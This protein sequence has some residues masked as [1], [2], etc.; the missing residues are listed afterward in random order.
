[1]P[2]SAREPKACRSCH[3]CT[4]PTT[5]CTSPSRLT[6]QRFLFGRASL[7]SHIHQGLCDS[8]TSDH[9]SL[10][11]LSFRPLYMDLHFRLRSSL[12]KR[13]P[14]PPRNI[15][16]EER[17]FVEPQR[18]DSLNDVFERSWRTVSQPESPTVASRPER[19]RRHKHHH[20]IV[21][22]AP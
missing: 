16:D 6:H 11:L 7:P 1:M 20:Q 2:S 18:G 22:H 4:T 13:S 14:Q 19:M 9:V 15:D 17:L 5:S 12:Y 21:M 8:G 10:A 3:A